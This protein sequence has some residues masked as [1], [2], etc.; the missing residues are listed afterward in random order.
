[1]CC[2]IKQKKGFT[3][4]ELTIVIAVALILSASAFLVLNPTKRIGQTNDA[5]RFEDVTALAKAVE[6]Y[7]I[8]ND[9]LPT[10]LATANVNVGHKVVLCSSA[11]TL[12]CDGQTRACLVLNDTDFFV[13]YLGGS[14]PVDPT[15]TSTADTGYYIGRSGDKMIFGAC[16]TYEAPTIEYIAKASLGVYSSTCGDGATEGAEVCDDGDVTTEGCRNGALD[17]AGTYCNSTCTAQIVIN[18][19]EVCDSNAAGGCFD[20]PTSSQ[21]HDRVVYSTACKNYALCSSDCDS[22]VAA[23]MGEP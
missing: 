22:C 10:T 21:Y 18:T 8:D 6:L 5:R 14:L 7:Q 4:V 3:L 15:K 11:A 16:D 19:S 12:S 2:C 17:L 1:M 20:W 23:C 9:A 13:N